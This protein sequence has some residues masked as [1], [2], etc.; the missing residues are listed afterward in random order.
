[1]I[2]VMGG[3]LKSATYDFDDPC[4]FRLVACAYG[5]SVLKNCYMPPVL[6]PIGCRL[7]ELW[8]LPPAGGLSGVC[9]Y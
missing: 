1:M 3:P 2:Y 9:Y 5:P 4:A 6:S 8:G 7:S